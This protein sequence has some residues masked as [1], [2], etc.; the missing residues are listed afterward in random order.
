MVT[1]T[2]NRRIMVFIPYLVFQV[3][4]SGIIVR[5]AKAKGLL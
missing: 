3:I 2:D 1:I 5:K 4:Y